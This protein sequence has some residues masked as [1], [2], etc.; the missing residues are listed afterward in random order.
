MAGVGGGAFSDSITPGAMNLDY[1]QFVSLSF[2]VYKI[3]ITHHYTGLLWRLNAFMQTS[4]KDVQLVSV[5][6]L[7]SPGIKIKASPIF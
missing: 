4:L 5:P 7:P 2:S 3:A 1:F 6:C